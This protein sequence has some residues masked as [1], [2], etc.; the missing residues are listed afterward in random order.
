M[1]FPKNLGILLKWVDRGYIQLTISCYVVLT[2]ILKHSGIFFLA[3]LLCACYRPPYNQFDQ[4]KNDFLSTKSHILDDLKKHDIQVVQY[5]E[6]ITLVVPTDR[7]YVFNSPR[8]HEL[9]YPG[10]EAIVSMI[11]L[12]PHAHIT[13]AAFCDGVGGAWHE[14]HKMTDA[15][16]HTMVAFLW[17]NGISSRQLKAE[18]LGAYF[19]IGDN[20][21][22]H[23]SAHNRRI[24]IQWRADQ[25]V[26]TH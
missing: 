1:A 26:T 11:R 4:R 7:Y 25:H 23:G 12:Y 22:I 15:R 19:P 8:L 16:A 14:Q 6:L 20:H 13:V 10:L 3:C 9:E 24:E 21:L 17:A 2:R 18:G 5:G